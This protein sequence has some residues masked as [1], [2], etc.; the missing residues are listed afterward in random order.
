MQILRCHQIGIRA[1]VSDGEMTDRGKA[2]VSEESR[3]LDSLWA[4]QESVNRRIDDLTAEE[5]AVENF[6]DYMEIEPSKQVKYVA[7]RLKG[8]A[9]AWWAQ[10][11]Q[12][13]QREGMRSVSE[14]TEEF[15]RLSARNNL[16]E[17][18]NQLVARYIRGLKDSIQEKL[19]LNSQGHKSNECPQRQQAHFAE[20]DEGGG[21]VGID[22][23]MEK[24]ILRTSMGTMVSL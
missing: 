17:S 15:N 16:S 24:A 19:E 3:T 22:S 20:Q 7:C 5:K 8:G 2:S 4:N 12:L 21:S 1:C 14:Y 23:E 10:T 11:L 18:A 6:F 13:R 9:S